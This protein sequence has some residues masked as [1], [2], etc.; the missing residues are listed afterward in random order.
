MK[1]FQHWR[2]GILLALGLWGFGSWPLGFAATV[3]VA[4]KDNFFD[5]ATATINVN[6]T[7]NWSWTGI[8][9]HSSTST[10]GLWD[11]GIHGNGFTFSRQ[12]TA[13]GNFPYF[14]RVHA[15]QT[16]SVVVQ[17]GGGNSPPSVSIT[18]PVNG[19]TFAAPWSGIIQATATDS[20]G[21]VTNVEFFANSVSL[22]SVASPPFN[23]NVNNIAAGTYTLTAVAKDNQGATNTSA[24]VSVS[25][26]TPVP[27]MLSAPQRSSGTQFRFTYTANA[28]L[29]YVVERSADL[30][31][32][33]AINTNTAAASS[34]T[35]T[36]NTATATQNFY[37]VRRLPN[38]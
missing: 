38:P 18:N 26:V 16:G 20:D 36:D 7:V 33:A 25:V 21:S 31:S 17:G 13:A 3:N 4:V 22:G 30:E 12:F 15:F 11:S 35:F 10:Q 32:F 34:V 14:C 37:R 24:G 5:P 8:S 6:D 28:G 23:R 29:R 27:I 9:T 19:A 1:N 2:Q